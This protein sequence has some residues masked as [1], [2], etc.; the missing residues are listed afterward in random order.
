[1]SVSSH[2]SVEG[3]VLV[4]IMYLVGSILFRAL[5]ESGWKTVKSLSISETEL[6]MILTISYSECIDSDRQAGIQV[7]IPIVNYI[8]VSANKGWH[9]CF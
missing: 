6:Y 5:T 2:Q 3:D 8:I 4:N 9:C 7:A 1:M